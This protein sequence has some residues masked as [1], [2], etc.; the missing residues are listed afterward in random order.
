MKIL[1]RVLNWFGRILLPAR[2]RPSALTQRV[3]HALDTSV[4][5]LE[6]GAG[7]A[8]KSVEKV[9]TGETPVSKLYT[10]LRWFLHFLLLFA[11]L[12][13]LYILNGYLQLPKV[14]HSVLPVLHP[15]WLPLLFLL[16]YLMGWF[17]W[18]LWQL[19]GPEKVGRDHPDVNDAWAEATRA[20]ADAGIELRQLPLFLVLGRPEGSED[21]LFEATGRALKVRAPRATTAPL[22]I[23]ADKDAIF[24]TCGTTSVVGALVAL[25]ADE[26]PAGE[27]NAKAESATGD[28]GDELRGDGAPPLAEIQAILEG[29][30]QQGRGP[31]QLTE[32]E[33]RVISILVAEEQAD[34]PPADDRR[35][36]FLRDGQAVARQ[37]ARLRHLCRLVAR[38]R[39]PYCPINGVLVVLPFR[40]ADTDTDAAQFSAALQ[41][42]LTVIRDV[43][44]VQCPLLAVSCDLQKTSGFREF[45]HRLPAGQRDRRL[46][47]RF[48]LAPDLNDN[49]LPDMV[50]QGVGWLCQTLVPSLVYNL[51]RVE[52]GQNGGGGGNGATTATATTT[53]AVEGNMRLYRFLSQLRERRQRFGRLLTRGLLVDQPD[54]FRFGGFYLAGTGDGE[55]DEQAFVSGV[56]DKL[57]QNQNYVA[58]TKEIVA[59]EAG[60][61]RW[62]RII[63]AVLLLLVVAVGVLLFLLYRA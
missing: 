37:Q 22:H 26:K 60:Y 19:T 30:Q 4:A 43:L 13:G 17:A 48:P 33:K 57:L 24:V 50:Q 56:V 9:E 58:W 15:Y 39:R 63:Y 1:M 5:G 55:K 62:T 11:I 36:A 31:D 54:A 40:A 21:Q 6:K 32:E 23:Y 35:R 34:R 18:G 51:F 27:A 12:Y 29:A 14:L 42:D 28:L 52:P 10:V 59:A 2:L 25:L 46:G 49:E 44:Q 45:L 47:Q 53:A 3:T 7:K 8:T 20:V 16:L 38:D 61:I 41:S